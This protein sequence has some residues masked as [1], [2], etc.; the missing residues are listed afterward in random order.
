MRHRLTPSARLASRNSAGHERE[1]LLRR[2]RDHRHHQDR[3]RERAGEGALT[4][5]GDD[6][7]EDEDADDDR[8]DPV[9][10]VEHDA[11]EGADALVGEL[12]DVDRDEHAHRHATSVAIATIRQLPMIASAIPPGSPKSPRGCVKK[13]RLSDAAPLAMTEPSTMQSIATAAT[14]LNVATTANTFWTMRRRRSPRSE[15]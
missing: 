12:G 6:H 10:H 3:E 15:R 7:P 4:A 5:A 11:N 2:A 9:H 14:A 8:G 1:H 13:S